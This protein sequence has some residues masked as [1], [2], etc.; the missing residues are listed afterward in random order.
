[1]LSNETAAQIVTN[2]G[3]NLEQAA[4]RLCR[5][6]SMNG[7]MDNISAIVVDLREVRRR[8]RDRGR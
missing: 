6:A 3:Q 1:M 7:S 5:E 8:R 4:K 2:H